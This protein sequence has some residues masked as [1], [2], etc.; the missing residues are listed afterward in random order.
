VALHY[1]E[2]ARVTRRSSQTTTPVGRAG[3]D[4]ES[5]GISTPSNC[6]HQH[7]LPQLNRRPDED[8]SE[9]HHPRTLSRTSWQKR[10]HSERARLCPASFLLPPA[11][12]LCP[13][14]CPSFVSTRRPSARGIVKAEPS[15][16]EENVRSY[17]TAHVPILAAEEGHL[18]D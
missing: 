5:S 8:D 14:I 1:C 13:A 10:L 4:G 12:Y 6:S 2:R 18:A 16:C 11:D 17:K 9:H 7:C 3:Q 15:V